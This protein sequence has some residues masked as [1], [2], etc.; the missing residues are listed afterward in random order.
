MDVVIDYGEKKSNPSNEA[1]SS[2]S[3]QPSDPQVSTPAVEMNVGSSTASGEGNSLM[4]ATSSDA[5]NEQTAESVLNNLP[6]PEL[7]LLCSLLAREG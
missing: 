3:E 4:Q 2:A 6:N 7:Q 5:D 1:G